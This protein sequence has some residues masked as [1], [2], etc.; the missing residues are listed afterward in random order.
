MSRVPCR[1]WFGLLFV[2]LLFC[3]I[4]E[5]LAQQTSPSYPPVAEVKAAFLKQ[6][7]RPRIPLD[8]RTRT[9]EPVPGGRVA[10]FIN[11]ASEKQA[12]GS[13]ERVPLVLVRP[14]KVTGRL[15]AVIVLHGTGGNKEAQR[16]FLVDL[17]KRGIIGVAVDARYHGERSGGA[18]GGDAY[19]AAITKAWRTPAGQPQEHPFYFDTC[20]D[21]W[22]VL[23]YLVERPDVDPTRV[24][25]VGFSMG[26]IQTWLAAAVE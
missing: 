18:K 19:M 14:V 21:L 24:A 12:D 2:S 6:L 9:T 8:P 11:L 17:S 16:D 10:E 22:R 5:P 1:S 15:P 7:D 13:I 3:G 23:D 20:W 26:G 25:M 4:R